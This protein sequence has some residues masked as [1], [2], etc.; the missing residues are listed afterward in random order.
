MPK[1]VAM[2]WFDEI[3]CSVTVCD[4][5][6]TI[7]YMNDRSAEVNASDG[8]KSLIGKNMLDCH[9][10]AARE[11]LLGV[12]ASGR[13]NIYTIE[14]NGQKKIICQSHWRKNGEVGGLVEITFVL[15]SEIPHFVRT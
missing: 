5:D 9:P 14:K 3:P 15:P 6:Y 8:G 7:L 2:E 13:P 4:T 11:K 10:P 12:M 1:P